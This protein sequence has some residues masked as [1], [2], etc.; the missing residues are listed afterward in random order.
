M[1]PVDLSKHEFTGADLADLVIAQ[2]NKWIYA[3]GK[4][5]ILDRLRKL[6]LKAVM[7]LKETQVV[8][9]LECNGGPCSSRI[10]N[11]SGLY[12]RGFFGIDRYH[13]VSAYK[14]GIYTLETPANI[15]WSEAMR[16]M[17]RIPS[18]ELPDYPAPKEFKNLSAAEFEPVR[19]AIEAFNQ[20]VATQA[21]AV[22]R[23]KTP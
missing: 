15:A 18:I 8:A 21:T 20:A 2:D 13:A 19:E 16:K 1:A 10:A 5:A 23:G 9:A 11:G 7:L 4:S 14:W 6:N 12:S 17:L 22:L 3:T